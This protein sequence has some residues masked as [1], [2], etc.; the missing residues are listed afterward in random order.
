[1]FRIPLEK[2]AAQPAQTVAG[3]RRVEHRIAPVVVIAARGRARDL[4]A[5]QRR[6]G[7]GARAAAQDRNGDAAFACRKSQPP[8]GD[9][10]QALG[11]AAQFQQHRAG[12]R[13]GQYVARRRQSFGGIACPHHNELPRIAAQFRKSIWRHRAIF[14]GFV[15]G[16]HPEERPSFSIERVSRRPHRQRHGKT[17]GA[18]SRREDFVQGTRSQASAQYGIRARMPQRQRRAV[19]RQAIPCQ[20]LAQ[21]RGFCHI[22]HVMFYNAPSP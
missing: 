2:K 21:F 11:H 1:M 14:H 3:Q 17:A 19:R 10:V 22:V 16:P 8:A 9:K 5:G 15:I 4:P 6:A 20:I 7:F 13:T 18:P 12:M